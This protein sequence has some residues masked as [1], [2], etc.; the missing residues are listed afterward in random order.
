MIR[1]VRHVGDGQDLLDSGRFIRRRM[2]IRLL[3]R[4]GRTW[5]ILGAIRQDI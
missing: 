3:S 5:K 2:V 4:A 1:S